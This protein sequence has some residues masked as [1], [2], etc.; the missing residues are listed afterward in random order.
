MKELK[1]S[2]NEIRKKVATKKG[3]KIAHAR[4]IMD[5]SIEYE[6]LDTEYMLVEKILQDPLM[7]ATR[8]YQ[9][10]HPNTDAKTCS[11]KASQII[12]SERVAKYFQDRLQKR[13][14]LGIVSEKEILYNIKQIAI[15]CQ[16]GE[17]VRDSRGE[18]TG[19]WKF[20]PSSALR[21]WELLG[22]NIGM[23]HNRVEIS[24]PEGKPIEVIDASM[25]HKD[26]TERYLEQLKSKQII[27]ARIASKEEKND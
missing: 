9:E 24:G 17:P 19:E 13:L 22:K 26:A 10:L 25:T 15:R 5:T 4:Q 11:R 23:F 21:A 20:E 27:E 1:P 2:R 7:N 16:Q 6:I 14:D 8:A 3:Q 18:Q 12:N